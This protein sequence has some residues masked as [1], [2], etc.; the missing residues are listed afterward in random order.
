[1]RRRRNVNVIKT[2]FHVE[3]GL[4]FGNPDELSKSLDISLKDLSTQDKAQVAS[5]RKFKINAVRFKFHPTVD[6]AVN[7]GTDASVNFPTLIGPILS[8][9]RRDGAGE[10]AFADMLNW[11][12]IKQHNVRFPFTRYTRVKNV[13]SANALENPTEI[14][15]NRPLWQDTAFIEGTQGTLC[16]AAPLQ[17]PNTVSLPYI[18]IITYYVSL[19]NLQ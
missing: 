7:S 11:S 19:A 1:M 10:T 5:F 8:S 14:N 16:V 9:F 12:N 15:M 18:V 6:T 4:S 3:K 13:I 17:D 2:K